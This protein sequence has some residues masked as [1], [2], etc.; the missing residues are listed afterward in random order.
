MVL[1]L[2]AGLPEDLAGS[3]STSGDGETAVN[4]QGFL[5]SAAPSALPGVPPSSDILPAL[6]LFLFYCPSGRQ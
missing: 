2:R 4:E 1:L 6:L 5:G 3:L